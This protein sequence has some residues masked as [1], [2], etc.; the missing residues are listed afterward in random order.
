[1]KSIFKKFAAFAALFAVLTINSCTP[2]TID[3]CEDV[4]CLNG[5]TCELGLCDCATG[6]E[7]TECGTEV[8]AKLLGTWRTNNETCTSG[9]PSTFDI[10]ITTNSDVT[11]INISNLYNV[12]FSAVASVDANNAV[13]IAS[14]PFGTGNISGSGSLSGTTLTL[15]YT[16]TGGG[17]S[18]N[19]NGVT[20][21]E[22]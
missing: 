1:M 13:T 4:T 11:K 8:R 22:L 19:C 12:G 18:D 3:P 16:V 14:Q 20:F 15:S 10:I 7:G 2:E 5:G 9:G 6:Y 21:S 17:A